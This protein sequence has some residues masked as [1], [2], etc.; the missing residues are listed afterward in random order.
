M[1]QPPGFVLRVQPLNWQVEP[2]KT[3][4]GDVTLHSR[5]GYSGTV[6]LSATAS[7]NQLSVTVSPT[8]VAIGQ[9]AKITVTVAAESKES[10]YTVKLQ[11]S[12]SLLTQ[13]AILSITLAVPDRQTYLPLLSR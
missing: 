12:D 7:S 5:D 2:G 9:S 6:M 13:T 4:S 11:A 1:S 10:A 3:Y 8:P